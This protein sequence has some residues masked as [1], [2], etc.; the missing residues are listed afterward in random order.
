[1]R[2]DRRWPLTAAS[3][4]E[5]IFT[6]IIKEGRTLKTAAGWLVDLC[7]VFAE[8]LD[9]IECSLA[10]SCSLFIERSEATDEDQGRGL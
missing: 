10:E 7:P 1:M 6:L 3:R 4:P 2:N 8:R 5:G 9:A